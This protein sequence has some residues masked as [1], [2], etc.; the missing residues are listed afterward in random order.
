MLYRRS[1]GMPCPGC[2]AMQEARGQAEAAVV[3]LKKAAQRVRRFTEDDPGEPGECEQALAAFWA[4]VDSPDP[5]AELLAVLRDASKRGR[6]A[7]AMMRQYGVVF[8]RWPVKD[9]HGAWTPEAVA[10]LDLETRWQGVAF[11]LYHWLVAIESTIEELG[12]SAPEE[13]SDEKPS[14]N[15]C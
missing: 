13:A 8:D 12:L 11:S 14:G 9:R 2:A 5:G 4:M 10:V 1:V 6:E 3:A 7:R 15:P